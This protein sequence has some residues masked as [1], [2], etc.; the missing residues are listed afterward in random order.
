[1]CA[2]LIERDGVRLAT[3]GG[4][5]PDCLR[6]AAKQW[7]KIVDLRM[8]DFTRQDGCGRAILE[9]CNGFRQTVMVKECADV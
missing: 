9:D 3:L 5:F 6:T 8:I 4:M 7:A 2:Y 1:M